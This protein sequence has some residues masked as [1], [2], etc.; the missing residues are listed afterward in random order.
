M[1]RTTR[2][3]LVALALFALA[4]VPGCSES[5]D[6][7][8]YQSVEGTIE[9]I[10]LASGQVTLLYFSKKHDR[11][12]TITGTATPETE[13]FINGALATLEDLREGERV[14]VV[15]WVKGHGTEKQVV[16]E[17]VNATRAETIR[18]SGR[19]A[20]GP[21]ASAAEEPGPPP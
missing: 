17:R 15:G 4:N 3:I 1:S 13:I 20:S 10:D 7:R 19:P 8:E 18:R 21:A 2:H 9:R 5:D 11:E 14:S 16:A 6:Q 12:V